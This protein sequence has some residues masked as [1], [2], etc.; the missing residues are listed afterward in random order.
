MKVISFLGTA[1]YARTTYCW[2]ELFYET[3]FFPDA[4]AQLLKPQKMLIC[5]TPTV[6]LHKNLSNLTAKLD[7]AGQPWQIVSIPEG[8]S[9]LDLWAIF[10]ALTS[11]IDD[12]DDVTFDVTHSFRSLPFLSFLAIAYLK[13]AKRVNVGKVLYGAYEARDLETNRS[14]VF[15]LTPF[16]GLLDWITAADQ[17]IQT[18]DARR[19]AKLLSPDPGLKS[20]KRASQTL[21]N[22]SQ[23]AFLCQPFT[24]MKE[25]GKLAENLHHAEKELDQ[26]AQ[27][28]RVLSEQIINVF[29]QFKA[30]YP[31]DP[32]GSLAAEIQ[33]IEW[34]YQNNQLLQAMTLAR[35]WLIDSVTLQ[36]H[37]PIDLKR[38]VRSRFEL[39]IS[40]LPK[41]GGPLKNEDGKFTVD[42]LNEFG[43]EIY[44]NWPQDVKDSIT[45]LWV[46]LEGVRNSLD[47]AEHQ[48]NPLPFKT[49]QEKVDKIIM[50]NLHYLARIWK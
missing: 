15:D 39:A 1:N 26:M 13:T 34:Y 2:D 14:P 45:K 46:A 31:Q 25:A 49:I 4:V 32:I 47:H 27:P 5:A 19:L 7:T 3:E 43:Q 50:P 33:M 29:G 17:F 16:V 21:S 48:A 9:E 24:L 11:A 42:H 40:G 12:G 30:N 44:N 8:H 20:S 23:A 28:Y 41:V 35:E 38:E 37:Q 10:N 36:L 18:G 6:Q 22:V